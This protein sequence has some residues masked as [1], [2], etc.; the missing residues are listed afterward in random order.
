MMGGIMGALGK[1][2]LGNSGKRKGDEEQFAKLIGS[3]KRNS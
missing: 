3:F 2:R 1:G